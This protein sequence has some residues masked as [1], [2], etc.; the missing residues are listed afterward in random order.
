MNKL[1]PVSEAKAKLSELVREA[2][3]D[4]VIIMNYG[5]PAAVLISDRRYRSLLEE[6]DDMADRLSIYERDGV[7]TSIEKV[8]AELGVDLD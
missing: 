2:D 6:M 5:R 8:A 1:V 7:T 3:D 4:D